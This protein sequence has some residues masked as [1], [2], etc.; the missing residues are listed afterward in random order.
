MVK[1]NISSRIVKARSVKYKY[2]HSFLN[3]QYIISI[4]R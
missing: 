2:I 1:P 3:V 4:N